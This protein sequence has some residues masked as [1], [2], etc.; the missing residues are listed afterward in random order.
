[1]WKMEHSAC[2]ILKSSIYH[3]F[4]K[5]SLSNDEKIKNSSLEIEFPY[6]KA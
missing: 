2:H 4:L 6:E 3:T 5:T 1:M